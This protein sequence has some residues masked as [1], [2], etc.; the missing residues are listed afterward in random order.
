MTIPCVPERCFVTRLSFPISTFEPS[1]KLFSF[2]SS[3]YVCPA[4]PPFLSH[5]R[6][7]GALSVFFFYLRLPLLL[8]HLFILI[9]SHSLPDRS[10]QDFGPCC[11]NW[12]IHFEESLFIATPRNH[13][14]ALPITSF[15]DI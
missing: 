7:V 3:N 1:L 9:F 10:K 5:P 14:F 15:F 11:A 8:S 13:E 2:I 12:F 4:L 6:C